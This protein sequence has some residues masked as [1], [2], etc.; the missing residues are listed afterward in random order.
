MSGKGCAEGKIL[1]K[2]AES[3][4]KISENCIFYLNENGFDEEQIE[5]I[6]MKYLAEE[7]L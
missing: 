6:M 3:M 4:K 5:S 7:K 1:Y 2:Y